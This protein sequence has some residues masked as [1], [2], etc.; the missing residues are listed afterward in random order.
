MQ[1]FYGTKLVAAKRM[2][3]IEYNAFRGW[4][5]PAD[6]NGEDDG[7]LVEY[8]DGGKPN[9]AAFNGYVSWSPKEQFE[10]AYQPINAL[11]FG[12]AIEALKTGKKVA[13]SGWNGK[14]MWLYLVPA[15][16]YPAQTEAAKEYWKD[17]STGTHD[18][19][20]L[21]PYGAYIAMK[22]AQE[23]VIPWLASQT[24]VLA[25]DWVIV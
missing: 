19:N 14:G 24:D 7:Y 13:R 11:S 22:T 2:T 3:R 1:Q 9:V 20:P 4:Q 23:N 21:V 18:G 12:H 25:E 6:E 5:L 10:K 8:Q 15:N 17:R 16:N